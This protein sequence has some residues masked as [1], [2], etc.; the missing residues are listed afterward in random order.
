M[1]LVTHIRVAGPHATAF[2]A[3]LVLMTLGL[4]NAAAA[5]LLALYA[6]LLALWFWLVARRIADPDVV[7]VRNECLFY[8]AA[9]NLTFQAMGGAIPAIREAR[10]DHL[11]HDLDLA[12]LGVNP[13]V[14]MQQ[15]A[16]PTLTELLSLCYMFFMPLLFVNLV[17]YFFWHKPLLGTFYR[18]LF[19]VYGVGFIGYLLVPAAGPYL[20][21]PEMFSVEL[22]GGPITHFTKRMVEFGSN[23]VDVFPSL[24][25]AVSAYILGFY[26]HYHRGHFWWLL[27]PVTGLWVSTIYLRYHYLVDVAFGFALAL[28]AI[29]LVRPTT[30]AAIT[31]VKQ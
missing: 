5:H 7:A 31:G 26:W 11:L 19:T 10:Y 17:R 1:R 8:A 28:L 23:R 14:W 20:A 6:T 12:M 4:L 21:F 30:P 16:T 27:V 15:F 22:T 25:C 13:N 3:Y 24:H 9:M 18:G 2:G 29:L